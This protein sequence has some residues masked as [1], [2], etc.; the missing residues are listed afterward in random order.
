MATY[1][2][3]LKFTEEARKTMGDLRG[4]DAAKQ[5]VQAM[6]VQ[7]KGWY[8]TLGQYDAVVVL[9]APDDETVAKLALVQAR[10]GGVVSETLRAFTEDEFRQ[11]A[12]ALPPAPA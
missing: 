7:W 4:L 5:A 8:M 6:G 10:A 9:E 12:A 1:V 2:V 11:F 3:L